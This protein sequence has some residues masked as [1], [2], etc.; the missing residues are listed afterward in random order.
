MFIQYKQQTSEV[1]QFISLAFSICQVPG[2][3][4]A[5]FSLSAHCVTVFSHHT[6]RPLKVNTILYSNLHEAFVVTDC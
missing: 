4:R 3:A 2:V 1:Y 6:I 5:L